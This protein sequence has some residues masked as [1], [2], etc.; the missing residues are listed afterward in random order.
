[1]NV[2]DSETRKVVGS[3]GKSLVV[4]GK[5]SG[6]TLLSS[7]LKKIESTASTNINCRRFVDV[8]DKEVCQYLDRAYL[9]H[10]TLYNSHITQS[11][12]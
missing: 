8:M 4:H 11:R 7:L 3:K 10:I 1:M 5:T 9:S 12:S 6:T 2:A